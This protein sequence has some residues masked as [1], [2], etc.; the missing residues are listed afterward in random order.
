M[1]LFQD[2]LP[3]RC[4]GD[5][6]FLAEHVDRLN[7]IRFG[8]LASF[9][10]AHIT[11]NVRDFDPLYHGFVW[12]SGTLNPL[13][14]HHVPSFSQF[15]F[16]WKYSYLGGLPHFKTHT[17]WIKFGL[18]RWIQLIW[19]SWTDWQTDWWV[20]IKYVFYIYILYIYNTLGQTNIDVENRH[21]N[22]HFIH[23]WTMCIICHPFFRS[24]W[25]FT[26]G[27][28]TQYIVYIIW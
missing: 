7:W 5:S 22:R 14:S 16:A 15:F 12:R 4:L 11:S 6:R 8:Y 1:Q 25:Q 28:I 3:L 2:L 20:D 13:V 23:K 9:S 19:F 18:I 21:F 27:Y 10:C 17:N 26:V 24:I